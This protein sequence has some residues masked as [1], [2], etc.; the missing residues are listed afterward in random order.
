MGYQVTTVT[1]A[2]KQPIAAAALPSMMILPAVLSIFSRMEGILLLADFPGRSQ[3]PAFTA[4]QLRSAALVFLANCLRSAAS[5]ASISIS[6]EPCDDAD[7]D[8][9][10]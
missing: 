9:G 5:T 2:N 6:I 8:H 7:I 4:P 3:S 1:P 10:S